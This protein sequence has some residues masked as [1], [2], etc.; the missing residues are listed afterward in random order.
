MRQPLPKDKQIIISKMIEALAS[1]EGIKAIALVGSYAL[2]NATTN[3]DVDLGIYYSEKSPP[4]IDELRNLAKQFDSSSELVIT[5]FYEWGPWVN[6]GAWLNTNAGEVDWLYRNLDQVNRVIAEAK[7]GKF[8]WDFR[9]QPPYG[10]M[11][12]MYLADLH[13]NISLFDPHG[14]LSQLKEETKIYPEELRRAIVQEHLWSIEFS[15]FNAAKFAQHGCIYGTVGCMTRIIAELTQV[16]FAFNR[17][18]FAT[19]KGALKIIESFSFKPT[20]YSNRIN[21]I[22]SYPGKEQALVVS[23]RKLNELIQEVIKLCHPLYTPKYL[24]E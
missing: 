20:E 10:Y 21:A 8:S 22:L 6:G 12:V 23:L 14:I 4:R 7:Q 9:Q 5:N 3:S 2:G 1:I 17:V 15:H 24:I 18:Y 16:L 19:E 11:S 13:N